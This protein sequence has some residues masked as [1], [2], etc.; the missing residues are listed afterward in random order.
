MAGEESVFLLRRTPSKTTDLRR[1]VMPVE[2]SMIQSWEREEDIQLSHPHI[3]LMDCWSSEGDSVSSSSSASTPNLS[4]EDRLSSD[5][6]R[7]WWTQKEQQ[8]LL[9][10]TGANLLK[11]AGIFTN[12]EAIDQ[13]IDR[14]QAYIRTCSRAL[15]VLRQQLVDAYI[16]Y[17]LEQDKRTRRTDKLTSQSPKDDTSGHSVAVHG[18]QDC[19]GFFRS[20]VFLTFSP[21]FPP[22]PDAT[23][24]RKQRALRNFMRHSSKVANQRHLACVSKFAIV[25]NR[26]AKWRKTTSSQRCRFRD[27][28]TTTWEKPCSNVCLPLLPVCAVHLVQLNPAPELRPAETGKGEG[29]CAADTKPHSPVDQPKTATVT[30]PESS[31]QTDGQPSWNALGTTTDP[32]RTPS[33][34]TRSVKSC[35]TELAPVS[36]TTNNV[37]VLQLPTQIGSQVI[38]SILNDI[39][40]ITTTSTNPRDYIVQQLEEVIVGQVFTASAGQNPARQAAVL[41]AF[42]VFSLIKV[43]AGQKGQDPI[44]ITTDEHPRPHTTL[45]AL[46]RL[47]PAFGDSNNPGTVTA[48]NASGV[49]DGAAFLLLCRKDQLTAHGLLDPLARVVGWYQVGLDPD[50][51]GMGPVGAI[52]GLLCQL[53]WTVDQVDA[54]ELNEA[55]AAQSIAV[56]KELRIPSEKLNMCGGGIALGHPLGCSGAR[57][58]VTLVHCLRRL[59]DERKTAERTLR[60]I[61]ALCIGGGMGI[62]LAVESCA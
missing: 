51:M 10:R 14:W 54:F 49:N 27:P 3:D 11:R 2:Q 19:A 52:R 39:S 23:T 16:P 17:A 30:P 57:I 47:Q 4:F 48:G 46:G 53:D 36:P 50:L 18:H 9:C 13:A 40:S 45:E 37:P 1:E 59:R 12:E 58:L 22:E 28:T 32:L 55:F 21:F 44:T 35:P 41:A 25:S 33:R 20:T 5:N 8:T 56:S 6:D 26:L 7:A 29:V 15:D 62:A 43:P 31:M 34:N 60:G 24:A 61:A 42:V 38:A